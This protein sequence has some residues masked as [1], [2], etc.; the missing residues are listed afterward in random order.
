MN[1]KG[2]VE[3]ERV[4]GVPKVRKTENYWIQVK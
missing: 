3:G 1:K 4:K 2:S